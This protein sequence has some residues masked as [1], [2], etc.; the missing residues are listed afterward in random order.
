ML[1]QPP[2]RAGLKRPRCDRRSPLKRTHAIVARFSGLA[3]TSRQ[4]SACGVR[5]RE[6][7][8]ITPKRTYNLVFRANSAILSLN[9]NLIVQGHKDCRTQRSEILSIFESP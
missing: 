9:T 6:K 8:C 4:A 2:G 7:P 3:Y 1:L 5:E